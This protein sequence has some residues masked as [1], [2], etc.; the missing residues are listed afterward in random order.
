MRHKFHNALFATVLITIVLIWHRAE[1][2]KSVV[3]PLRNSPIPLETGKTH[4]IFA[5]V[6]AN[7]PRIAA[8][9]FQGYY[10]TTPHGSFRGD[11]LFIGDGAVVAT[12]RVCDGEAH[13]TITTPN[14]VA[15]EFYK[16]IGLTN[17]PCPSLRGLFKMPQRD[18][19]T[20]A[21]RED[22]GVK[23]LD[24]IIRKKIP[25]KTAT[26]PDNTRAIG[27]LYREF[28]KA[29]GISEE[30]VESW[31]GGIAPADLGGEAIAAVMDGKANALFQEGDVPIAP[32][33]K[34][35]NQKYPM[36]VISIPDSVID[37][38][39]PLGFYK[40]EYTIPKGRY[41]GFLDN[42]QTIDYSDWIVLADAS[43]PDDI[44][45]HMAKIAAERHNDFEAQYPKMLPA[46]SEG[47]DQYVVNP[48]FMWKDLGAPIH[49]GAAKYFK[50][51]GLMP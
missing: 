41:P 35:L 45:Y 1:A 4:L 22:L 39:K 51:K 24:D 27:F 12:K 30:Q 43:V 11:I 9:L 18:L 37:K 7:F 5:G 3:A 40:F 28:L 44:A 48:K 47:L 32:N 42:V 19:I 21:V 29:A 20:F 14:A 8:W 36:R 25:L 50:E 23:T 13:F 38:L 31:G 10:S 49:P 33:W 17:K 6:T 16:G 26:G 2:Q 46:G 15:Y 34:P